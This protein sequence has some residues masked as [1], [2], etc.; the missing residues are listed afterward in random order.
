MPAPETTTNGAPPAV[1]SPP[2]DD[3]LQVRKLAVEQIE[4]K[5][6]FYTRAFAIACVAAMLVIIWAITEYNNAGGWPTSGFSQSSSIPHKWN[7]WIIYP[8][9]ALALGV[10]IDWW[11]T[12][13]HRPITEEQIR[14]EM[15]RLRGAH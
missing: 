12:Y 14:R 8:L 5:R 1:M 2:K 10:A 11:H 3:E 4:R 9:V 15:E 13:R 6:R 7:S